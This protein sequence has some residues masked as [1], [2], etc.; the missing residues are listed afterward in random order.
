MTI[1]SFDSIISSISSGKSRKAIFQKASSNG[2]TSAAGRFHELFTATGIPAAG[3]FS[4]TAGVATVMNASTAGALS[5][6]STV[7]PD[8]MHLL[9]I[10][11]FS[12]TATGVPSRLI[13]CDF[14]LY[15]PSCVVTGTP[16]TLNN[17]ATLPRY[18]DGQGVQA[19]IAVQSAL[20]AASPA[21]T[22]SYTDQSGNTGNSAAAHTSPAVS[23][24]IS[25]LFQTSGA[26][27]LQMV[28]ADSGIRK[29]DSYTLASGTTGTVAFILVK[30]LAEIPLAVVNTTVGQN[31]LAEI[32][33]LPKIE[34]G[35]CLGFI[36][37]TGN[38]MVTACSFQG[39]AEFVWG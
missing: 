8:I 4:G 16:T 33:S 34:D 38:A 11:A 17:A 24:S 15:Y 35:A 23:A 27:F 30:P 25:T 36:M 3:T 7:S 5:I 13:L 29:I 18:T 9:N 12:P 26:P 31:M 21:L 28:G 20:G 1:S 39:S 14:L 19:I 6:P 10:N 32:P 2:A 22:L 37:L